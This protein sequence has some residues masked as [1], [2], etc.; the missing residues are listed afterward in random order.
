M[1]SA[2]RTRLKSR[3]GAIMTDM[4]PIKIVDVIDHKSGYGIQR[5]VVLNRMPKKL[6]EQKGRWLVGND[7]PI[8]DV[9][10]IS[11]GSTKAFG[12]RKFDLQMKDGSVFNCV[13]QVWASSNKELT[14]PVYALAASTAAELY[15]CNVFC[16]ALIEKTLV[17]E[18]LAVNRPS[19]NYEKYSAQ[20]DPEYWWSFV[21]NNGYW[22]RRVS[23]QRAA[24]LRKRGTRI[25]RDESGLFW[26]ALFEQK[27]LGI[28]ARA[29]ADK[30]A[31]DD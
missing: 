13:G 27:R 10:E 21:I 5:F 31:S 24:F 9:L 16:S 28:E 12:G 30:G 19:N 18:W 1:R 3:N 17:D 4:E 11:P 7:G 6:Y 23:K 2:I 22:K 15:R 20:E 8:W 25:G 29:R 26:S 14:P